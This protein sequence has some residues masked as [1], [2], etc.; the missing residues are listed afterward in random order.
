[1][2]GRNFSVPTDTIAKLAPSESITLFQGVYHQFWSDRAPLLLGEVSMVN[3]D[4]A[5]NFFLEDR[6]RFPSI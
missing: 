2:A 5:D 4:H 6:G 3:N 1:V